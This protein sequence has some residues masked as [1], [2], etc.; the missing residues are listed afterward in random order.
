MGAIFVAF[1]ALR[2]FAMNFYESPKY[3]IGK[4]RDEEAIANWHAICKVN[5]R[6]TSLTLEHLREIDAKFGVDY[7]ARKTENDRKKS[8]Q[9]HFG[10]FSLEHI[11]GLFVTKK[12]AWATSVLLIVWAIIGLAFPLYNAFLPYYLRTRVTDGD[13]S[14]Y[15]AYRDSLIIAVVGFPASII[16]GLLVRLPRLGRRGT[17][18]ISTVL[19]GV[20][21]LC[22]TTSKTSN[23]LLGWNCG[24]SFT[25]G[26][27]VSPSVFQCKVPPLTSHPL[28]RC[29]LWSSTRSLPLKTP[30]HG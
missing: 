28:V 30:W 17:L 23:A 21:I 25:S 19:T 12:M 6:E 26:I 22:S 11:K 2:F 13:S 15:R 18:A 29:A 7:D 9:E 4:G 24:Y 5:K 20:F 14:T 1:W 27:L 8:V 10:K 16:G 3:L